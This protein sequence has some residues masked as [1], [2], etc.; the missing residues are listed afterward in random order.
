MTLPAAETAPPIFA[1]EAVTE[2]V[3]P[4]VSVPAPK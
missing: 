3:V 4:A 1:D 2:M